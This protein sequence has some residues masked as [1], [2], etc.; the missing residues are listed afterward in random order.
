[1]K[2]LLLA[3]AIVIVALSFHARAAGTGEP[4][5]KN[6]KLTT[7]AWI[8]ANENDLDQDNRAV[9]V[10]GKV[11]QKHDGD[12][13]FFTDGTGQIELDSDIELPVGKTI[14]VRG[15][16]DQA[17]LHIGPLEINV[18]SWRPVAKPGQVLK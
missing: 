12:T 5:A 8:K 7:I 18:D 15:R 10:I 9:A 14:V 2:R 16:V 6:W 1:M 13:Y 17:F 3:V 4:D 11:T